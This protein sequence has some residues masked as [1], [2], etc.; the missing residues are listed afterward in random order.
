MRFKIAIASVEK[1]KDDCF[2]NTCYDKLFIKIFNR[3][4]PFSAI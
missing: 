3:R 1:I 4:Y 2:L